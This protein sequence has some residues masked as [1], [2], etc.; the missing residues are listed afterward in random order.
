M[1]WATVIEK[2]SKMMK[3]PTNKRDAGEGQ[4]RRPQEAEVVAGS[5]RRGWRPGLA[6][7]ADRD[8]AGQGAATRAA[9][10]CGETPG[11]AAIYMVS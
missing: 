8:R 7:R 3:A 4:Q 1:R 10:C 5:A 9:S 11:L 6:P 2:L